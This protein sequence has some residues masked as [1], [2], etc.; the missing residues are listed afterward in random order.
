MALILSISHWSADTDQV[1]VA[2]APRTRAA[3]DRLCGTASQGPLRGRIETATLGDQI[4]T[5]TLKPR[6]KKG[7][8]QIRVQ[9]SSI[10]VL[11]EHP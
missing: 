6:T 7:C 3:V 8:D 2:L 11:R 4:V 5:I 1:A 9:A 10:I